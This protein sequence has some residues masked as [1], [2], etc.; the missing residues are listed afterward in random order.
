TA[1]NEGG[2]ER[3]IFTLTDK[4]GLQATRS[5]NVT[6]NG[7]EV[8]TGNFNHIAGKCRGAFDLIGV[9]E[10]ASSG[11]ETVKDLK[12]TDQAG[13]TF[14][15]SWTAG[16]NNGTLFREALG[17][18]NYGAATEASIE[19][20]Y[21]A[22]TIPGVNPAPSATVTNPSAGDVYLVKLRGTNRFAAIQIT[23]VNASQA[24]CDNTTSPNN[25]GEITFEYKIPG[26]VVQN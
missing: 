23:T 8:R 6:T 21:N 2:T 20:A 18:F 15:G 26:D 22:A 14:T 12:N 5:L 3:F 7:L 24:N 4:D 25:P 1:K 10:I 16:T 17:T 19:T 11:S 9:A 13:A